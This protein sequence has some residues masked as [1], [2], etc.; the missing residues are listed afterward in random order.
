[1]S[2]A[3]FYVFNEIGNNMGQSTSVI[4]ALGAFIAC[5]TLALV[6]IVLYMA[7]RVYIVG[8]K[9]MNTEKA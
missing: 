9:Q 1:M 3:G 8:K 6:V 5:T 4:G 7:Y 2:L